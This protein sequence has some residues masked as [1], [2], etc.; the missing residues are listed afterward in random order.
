LS[1]CDLVFSLVAS[2]FRGR[3]YRA[4]PSQYLR[5]ASFPHLVLSPLLIAPWFG[6]GTYSYYIY[7]AFAS[8]VL[9][10]RSS[11]L[12]IFLPRHVLFLPPTLD[13]ALA[14]THAPPLPSVRAIFSSRV[15]SCAFFYSARDRW[16]ITDRTPHVS[17]VSSSLCLFFLDLFSLFLKPVVR[18]S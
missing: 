12:S 13:K 11:I 15:F 17:F 6:R 7:R 2:P 3:K 14:H 4:P 18:P 10:T 5:G 16:N 1:S 8:S 9:P